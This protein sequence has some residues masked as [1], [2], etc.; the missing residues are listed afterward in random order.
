MRFG[1]ANPNWKGGVSLDRIQYEKDYWAKRKKQRKEIARKCYQKNKLKYHKK[2]QQRYY[3]EEFKLQRKISD[4]K[5]R[6]SPV[7][8]TKEE[9]K[10]LIKQSRYC[11][12]CREEL[13][14][15]FEIDHKI[16]LCRGGINH[17]SNIVVSCVGCNRSKG[18]MTVEEFLGVHH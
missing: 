5:R 9:L 6:L 14:G 12:Y 7:L 8:F 3:T 18:K 15:K 4:H 1:S 13:N 16:P 2:R 10:N 17:I 11:Y